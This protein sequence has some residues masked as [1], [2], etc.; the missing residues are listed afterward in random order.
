MT[1][2]RWYKRFLVFSAACLSS[3][4]SGGPN[5]AD[6]DFIDSVA[7]SSNEIWVLDLGVDEDP[8]GEYRSSLARLDSLCGPKSF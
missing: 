7:V 5:R 3:S 8:R 6:F 2:L 4:V 1:I